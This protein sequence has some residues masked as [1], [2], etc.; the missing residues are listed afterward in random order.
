MI[1]YGYV[2]AYNYT[3]VGTLQ[4]KIRIPSIH[5]PYDLS[6]YKGKPVRN[7]VKDEDLP[8]YDSVLLPYLPNDG[9]VAALCTMNTSNND[10]MVIG[11]TGGSYQAGK[12]I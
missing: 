4:L 9:E 8:Y 11:L 6:E 7:Y 2:K 3:N 5:G 1:I 10:F 12:Y